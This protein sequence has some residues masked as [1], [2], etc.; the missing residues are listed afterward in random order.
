VQDRQRIA[1][2]GRVDGKID[3]QNNGVLENLRR[4]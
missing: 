1:E 4:N 2:W 3:S